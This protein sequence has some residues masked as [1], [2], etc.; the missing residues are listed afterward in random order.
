MHPVF[1]I[2]YMTDVDSHLYMYDEL[3]MG[4]RQLL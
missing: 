3:I 4:M 2:F 1:F